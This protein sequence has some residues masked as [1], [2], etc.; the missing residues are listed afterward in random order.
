MR[1]WTPDDFPA[2][3]PV[4]APDESPREIR[5]LHGGRSRRRRPRA[6]SIVAALAFVI[7]VPAFGLGVF[8]LLMILA[9][10]G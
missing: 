8:V 3:I 5:V 2:S 1:D 7:L 4:Y 9:P 6:S 10:V